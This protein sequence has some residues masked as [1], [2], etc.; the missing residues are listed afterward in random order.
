[1]LLRGPCRDVISKGQ[2]QLRVSSVWEVVKRGLQPE[3]EESPL[4]EAVTRKRLVKTLK[5]GEDLACSD[6]YS[7]EVSDS[8]IV[9]CSYDL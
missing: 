5:A 7:V 9:I 2:G 1:V 4:L 3:A 8:V 6:L